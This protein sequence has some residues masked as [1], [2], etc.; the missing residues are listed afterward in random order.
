MLY[1]QCI[2][3]TSV[4]M[5]RCLALLSGYP[6]SGAINGDFIAFRMGAKHLHERLNEF[7]TDFMCATWDG[8]GEEE[9]CKAF[10]PIRFYSQDQAQFQDSIDPLIRKF[11]VVLRDKK[12][13]EELRCGPQSSGYELDRYKSPLFLRGFIINRALEEIARGRLLEYDFYVISRFDISTRG[14]EDVRYLKP[15]SQEALDFLCNGEHYERRVVM[16]EFQQLNE[17]YPDMW[18]YFNY[19]GLVRYKEIYNEYVMDVTNNQSKYC[20][21]MR[22]GWPDS[23]LFSHENV[24][25]VERFSNI[26]IHGSTR[27]EE[28]LGTYKD[29]H[30]TNVHCYHK[31]FFSL[32]NTPYSRMYTGRKMNYIRKSYK[33]SLEATGIATVQSRKLGMLVYSHSDYFDVLHAFLGEFSRYFADTF[34]LLIACNEGGKSAAERLS[35]ETMREVGMVLT[36]KEESQY[37]ERLVEVFKS[38]CN[39]DRVVFLHEDMIPTARHNMEVIEELVG[40]SR[41][42]GLSWLGLT[43][44][45]SYKDKKRVSNRIS[46]ACTGYRYVVQ[47]A[48]VEVNRW[49]GQ[50]EGL[51]HALNIWELEEYMKNSPDSVYFLDNPEDIKRGAGHF[52][53]S[54]FPHIST[55]IVKGRWNISEYPVEIQRL[56]RRYG[57]KLKNRGFC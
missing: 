14:C 21:L 34:D 9:I 36:Y 53:V 28:Q 4:T 32:G 15:V 48:I 12:R 46:M 39:R 43:K 26:E 35:L 19:A 30:I 18:F 41:E 40:Y 33:S 45:T 57:I 42:K 23:R 3:T 51:P 22:M 1:S 37:T 56:S 10:N 52:D 2:A 44:N 49:R 24:A 17:G 7:E 29:F 27:G 6:C 54:D 47:P 11:K 5:V 31:Y 25:D 50:L 20:N 16:P 8:V 38:I 13:I 55:A